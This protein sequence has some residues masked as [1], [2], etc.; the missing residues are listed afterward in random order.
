MPSLVLEAEDAVEGEAPE[1]AENTLVSLRQIDEDVA[2]WW[3]HYIFQQ[4][5]K[6]NVDALFQDLEKVLPRI[7][8]I[9]KDSP[10]GTR[11]SFL[12]VWHDFLR[13]T[14]SLEGDF[15]AIQDK[16][17]LLCKNL[18]RSSKDYQHVFKLLNILTQL[19]TLYKAVV[20]NVESDLSIED[21]GGTKGINLAEEVYRSKLSRIFGSSKIPDELANIKDTDDGYSEGEEKLPAHPILRSI[22]SICFRVDSPFGLTVTRKE[23]RSLLLNWYEDLHPP[24]LTSLGYT[25]Q[26]ILQSMGK[27]G[28]SAKTEEGHPQDGF[29]DSEDDMGGD[30]EATG[31]VESDN[32]KPG[33]KRD[34]DKSGSKRND[35]PSV[36]FSDDE[37]EH[38]GSTVW[39]TVERRS[40][41]LSPVARR[42]V[43]ERTRPN[44]S[45]K[46][47]QSFS[48]R[49][50]H[51]QK[52]QK[53]SQLE[54]DGTYSCSHLFYTLPAIYIENPKK[55]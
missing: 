9:Q 7:K 16:I 33:S 22:H 25:P 44:V 38:N 53:P 54:E 17:I 48:P 3:C 8:P 11:F 29:S 41:T 14:G 13:G 18:G 26:T 37:E 45:K 21:E 15:Q 31:E 6:E 36:W 32:D 51:R 49:F 46:R 19:G 20:K 30:S 5:L 39:D 2:E 24:K 10:L 27:P 43:L 42:K 12:E 23:I 35:K 28:G 52:K 1:D 50:S 55:I 47:A 34:S 40:R 4:P